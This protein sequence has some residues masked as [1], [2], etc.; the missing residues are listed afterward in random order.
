MKQLSQELFHACEHDL[1]ST[2][3]KPSQLYFNIHTCW[4]RMSI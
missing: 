3:T 1:F 2:V 4:Q